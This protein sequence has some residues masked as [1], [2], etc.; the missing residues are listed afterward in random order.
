[1]TQGE[2]REQIRKEKEKCELPLYVPFFIDLT[3]EC[4]GISHNY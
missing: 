2:E 3:L 1:M 4:A